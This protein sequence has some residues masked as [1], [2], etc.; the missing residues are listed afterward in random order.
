MDAPLIR[1]RDV[2][3]IYELGDV[4]VQALR[5]VSLDIEAGEFLAVMGA[6]G[7]GKSTFMNIV[8]CLDRPTR[9]RY[10]LAGHRRV[11]PVGGRA[12]RAPQPPPRLRLPEL[13]PDAAHERAR[14]RRAAVVLRRRPACTTSTGAPPRRWPPWVWP[15]ASTTC[16]A[17]SPA[18]SSSA[19]R[20]PA[21]WSTAPPWCSPTS[22]PATSTARRAPRSWRSSATST[23]S[24]ASP[25]CWSRTSRTSPRTRTGSSPSATGRW[26]PTCLSVARGVGR[27]GRMKLFLMTMRTALRALRRNKLRSALTMLGIIIGV[28]AV[29]AMVS[30]GQGA[31]AAVQQQILSLGNNMLMVVP[32][33]TTSAG[34]RS[35]WGGVSTLTVND[36]NGDRARLPVG[37]RGDLHEARG[38]PGRSTATRTGRRRRRASRRPTRRCATGRWRWVAS[39]PSRT[40]TAASR[41]VGAGADGGR[42]PVRA[43]RGSGRSDRAHQGRALSRR[44]R[45]GVE[46]PDD[47]G[48]GPGR[49]RDHPVLDRRAPR[50]GHLSSS[51]A[52]T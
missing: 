17:S 51:A 37:R 47:V 26:S 52:S 2:W 6:S 46:G 31:N 48:P 1:T 22:R 49:H 7:S 39:S 19:S 15:G 38:R 45:A 18:G 44:R 25:S 36:A 32:G 16:R 24:T 8:G 14:E 50:A 20:L 40:T 9:G 5:G 34:V 41:V 12:R 35:G 27:A 28:A 30:I 13:Q 10:L 4:E 3:K 21:P 11:D 43:G 23:A 29:I 42:S 33:A